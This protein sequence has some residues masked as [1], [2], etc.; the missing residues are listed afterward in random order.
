MADTDRTEERLEALERGYHQLVSQ[1]RKVRYRLRK[2]DERNEE[3]AGIVVALGKKVVELG[4]STGEIVLTK[5]RKKSGR[6]S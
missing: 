5:E 4:G 3:L 2:S 1:L 6:V